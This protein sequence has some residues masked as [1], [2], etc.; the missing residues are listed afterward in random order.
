MGDVVFK[1]VVYCLNNLIFLFDYCVFWMGGDE[2]VIIL[3]SI[4]LIE[5]MM[6]QCMIKQCFDYE[7]ELSG[8][9]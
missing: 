5:Q 9:L 2:F 7:F 8:D 6:M 1:Q 3:S 4:N